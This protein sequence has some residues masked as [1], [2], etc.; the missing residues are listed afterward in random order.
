M[1][2]CRLVRGCGWRIVG[3]WASAGM[4]DGVGWGGAGMSKRATAGVQRCS[5]TKTAMQDG[6]GWVQCENGISAESV[7]VG[8]K[9]RMG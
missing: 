5:E 1:C 4:L 9:T 2:G 7:G 3:V 6:C 8:C